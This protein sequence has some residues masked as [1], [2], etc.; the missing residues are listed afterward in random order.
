MENEKLVGRFM[1]LGMNNNLLD[2]EVC[3]DPTVIINYFTLIDLSS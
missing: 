1:E 2:M 3:N